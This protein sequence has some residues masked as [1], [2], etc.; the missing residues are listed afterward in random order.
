L[1]IN[2]K[3]LIGD[4][5][6]SWNEPVEAVNEIF[7][8]EPHNTLHLVAPFSVNVH[9]AKIGEDVDIKG[10]F[11]V[12][13]EFECDR[14]CDASS[15]VIKDKFHLFL[16]PKK[17]YEDEEE[18]D[19]EGEMELGYYEEEVDLS[20]YVK[21]LLLLALPVKLLCSDTCRGICPNCG[22]NLNREKCSCPSGASK[23]SPFDILK[24][25]NKRS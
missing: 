4:I 19:E 12:K 16:M 10:D 5:D 8:G 13:I 25:K 9:L 7:A 6:R 15:L 17:D 14:C 20:E 3:D 1:I 21:E 23:K 2:V 24:N 18:V 22:A 11:N